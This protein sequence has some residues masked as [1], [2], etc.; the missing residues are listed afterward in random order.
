MRQIVAVVKRHGD[1]G[2]TQFPRILHPILV[3]VIPNAIADR[4]ELDRR[5]HRKIGSLGNRWSFGWKGATLGCIGRARL[6][7]V[8][9]P[10]VAGRRQHARIGW[11]VR[12]RV[13][14]VSDPVAIEI[15]RQIAGIGRIIGTFVLIVGDAIAVAIGGKIAGIGCIVGT[16]VLIVVDAIAVAVGNLSTRILVVRRRSLGWLR[17]PGVPIVALA[18]L[19]QRDR[20]AAVLTGQNGTRQWNEQCHQDDEQG[21]GSSE[22]QSWLLHGALSGF[23]SGRSTPY[24]VSVLQTEDR[25]G[26][27]SPRVLLRRHPV[28]R[29]ISPSVATERPRRLIRIDEKLGGVFAIG[30]VPFAGPFVDG[31]RN[32]APPLI[33]RW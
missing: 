8:R 27:F 29:R 25:R 11:I 18:V 33:R 31:S 5:H 28:R 22:M 17:H 9:D 23:W 7:I 15:G 21:D 4:Y 3:H 10:V 32:P 6:L 19:R 14:I 20:H 12:A 30:V 26:R 16:C 2:R 24:P 1:P 13:L